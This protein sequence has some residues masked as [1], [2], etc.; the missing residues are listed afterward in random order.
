M[1]LLFD[2]QLSEQLCSQLSDLFPESRHVRGLQAGGAP[3]T[4]LVLG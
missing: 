3:D 4:V 1:R 2:E